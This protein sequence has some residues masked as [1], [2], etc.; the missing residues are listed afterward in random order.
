MNESSTSRWHRVLVGAAL[1]LVLGCTSAGQP[2]AAAGSGSQST[3]GRSGSGG[4]ASA[5]AGAGPS[6]GGLAGSLSAA[7]SD[8][9]AG[10]AGAIAG[11]SGAGAANSAGNGG[12]AGLAGSGGSRAPRTPVYNGLRGESFNGGWKFN[13]GDVSDGQSAAFNDSSWRAVTL[14]HDFSIELAFSSN[15]PS[16]SSGGYLDGGIGWYRKTFTL[17]Q[18]SAAKRVLI[19]FDGAYMNSQVWINGSLL[20]TRPYGYSSFEYDLTPYVKFDGS[21]NVIAVKVNNKQP[22]S[23]FYSG[24]GIYRNVWLTQVDPIHVPNGGVFVSPVVSGAAATVSVTTEVQNQSS[25]SGSVTVST[26][27]TGADGTTVATND[28]PAT[29]VAAAATVTVQQSLAVSSPQL[30]SLSTPTLY[31]VKVEVKVAGAIVDSY[32]TPMGIRTATFS[33]TSGF[34]LNGQGMKL[35][36][37]NMHHDLGALGAAVNYRAIERQVEILKGMGVNAIRTSHNPPAPE[38]LEISDRLGVLILDE[39]FDTWEQTKTANDYGLYFKDWAERDISAMVRRDRNHPSVILWSIG[40]EVG[41]ATTATATKLKN[42]V[43]DLDKTRALTWGSNKMGGPHVSEGDDRAVANLLDV[44][45]YNYAPYAGNYDSDHTAN[46]SWKLLGTEISAAVRTR[47]VYHTP[48]NKVTL[49]TSQAS[50]DRQCSSYDNEA[51]GFGATAESSYKYDNDRPF[52]AGSFIWA[53]F[54]YIGEPTPY[55]SW[56]SKSSYFGAIDTA[57]FPKDVYYFYK[58]VWTNQPMVHLLPHWNWSAGTTVTVYAYNNCDSVELFLNDQSQ[59]VKTATAAALHAEWS[60]P[61]AS[62][63]LRAD[64][65]KGGSV[66]A[67]DTVKT[68]GAAAKLVLSADRSP[69]YA[70]GQDLVFVTADVQDSSGVFVPT[71]NPSITF[72]VTGPGQLVGLDNGDPTDTTSYK[73]TSR[74]AFNGKAL[75]IVRSSGAAGEI[76]IS[77]SSN[78]LSAAPIVVSAQAP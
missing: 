78:G 48:A 24:S 2:S 69:I 75:A 65:K 63:T 36:G 54:D 72:T 51:A 67:T 9:T 68:A 71:A 57:G 12:S 61:W 53:G 45:G 50:A 14:P 15:S 76:T 18:A 26:T 56:P 11:S 60:V 16:G 74:K 13:R 10:S 40:N 1:S 7:G 31:R 41:G 23:R 6:V 3:A 19:E 37:V 70:D 5:S 55:S 43:L 22:N 27:I 49:A 42:W 39:A 32:V 64:C 28:S 47:G 29:A 77:A 66:V 8:S 52:V 25:D 30:W 73:G 38:L 34:A 62:G 59:G 17:G 58:S 44:A 4:A 46:P 20:G 21:S 33:A 35:R